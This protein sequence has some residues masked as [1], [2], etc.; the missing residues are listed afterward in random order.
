[1]LFI[2]STG[3]A[4]GEI[5]PRYRDAGFFGINAE[6]P[7]V[8]VFHGDFAL[9]GGDSWTDYSI[10]A[11]VSIYETS[12]AGAH[13]G[14]IVRSDDAGESFYYFGIYPNDNKWRHYSSGD[15]QPV[16][17]SYSLELA[18]QSYDLKITAIQGSLYL[19]INGVEVGSINDVSRLSGGAGL[20]MEYADASF[21]NVRINGIPQDPAEW[22]MGHEVVWSGSPDGNL[23][24]NVL[25]DP[26][27][28]AS[29]D[30]SPELDTRF[31]MVAEMGARHVRFHLSWAEIQPQG[32][33]QPY[34]WRYADALAIAAS[35]YGLEIVPVVIYAPRWAV[36]PE[37]RASKYYY[38]YPP[39][40]AYGSLDTG[41][42][43]EFVAA[44]AGRYMKDGDLAAAMNWNTPDNYAGQA[45]YF[46]IGPEYNLGTLYE[47][48]N[49]VWGPVG[50]GW[51]GSLPQF[52]DLLMAGRDAVKSRCHLCQVLNG[53]AA[54]DSI[55][56]YYIGDDPDRYDGYVPY[57]DSSRIF[58]P[59]GTP[60]WR[61][62]VWQGVNDLYNE[63]ERR[64]PPDNVP[65]RYFDILNIHTFMWK[66][67]TAEMPAT[68]DRYVNCSFYANDCREQWYEKRL[69]EVIRVM[70]NHND[71]R[72]I[73][74]TETGFASARPPNDTLGF[75][76]YLS[77]IGQAQAL[78]TAYAVSARYP[79]VKKVFWWQ[80]YDSSYTGYL[81]LINQ[82]LSGKL[83][84]SRFGWMTGKPFTLR[85]SD[86]FT[87]YDDMHADNW[88]LMSNPA[89]SSG[90]AWFE[91]SIAGKAMKLPA[92]SG[93]NPGQIPP[94]KTV[95]VRYKGL[96]GGPVNAGY[97]ATSQ[98]LTSQRT[99]W[100]G[101][102]LEEVTG[103]AVRQSDH[104]YWAWYDQLSSGYK[105]WVLVSNPGNVPAFYQVKIAGAVKAKGRVNPGRTIPHQFAGIMG[106][107]VEVLSCADDFTGPGGGCLNPA[108]VTASQRVLM[109]ED[110][111]FN[112]MPGIPA[113]GL[114]SS[115][116]W[117]WYD[118]KSPGS[119]NWVLIANPP[120]AADPI[121]Y[122][123][124]VAGKAL[125][126]G[127]PVAPGTSA[128]PAF[129]G[130]MGGPVEVRTYSDPALT[131]PAASI[132]SQRVL[133]GK[134]FEEVPGYRSE[135]LSSS[136]HWTWYDMK[137]PGSRNWVL[138]ANPPEA[139]DPIY[140]EI[141]VAGKALAAGGP[142]APGTSATPAFPGVMG[143][144]VEVRTYSDPALTVPAASIASQRVLWGGYIHELA[145]TRLD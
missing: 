36:T 134:S 74:L 53:G 10:E 45:R 76:G 62:T 141:K 119:R 40:D 104:F 126:A 127:G 109:S 21:T 132:A 31:R 97:S 118:M 61:Q 56:N 44:A 79:Q 90:D 59:D 43:S 99:L 135:L 46:E 32:P 19:F 73:W 17:G 41:R 27:L 140:Y 81:G 37:F 48:R 66:G 64:P 71:S 25:L 82:D 8:D 80:A 55:T 143:G 113:A 100:A 84:Y 83:S 35:R 68:V 2:F 103:S 29:P 133:W 91:L 57:L 6:R 20:H 117:T 47:W 101:S 138:I 106:G 22:R 51:L 111:D 12:A 38:A 122:E 69:E 15:W 16:E 18:P 123:I 39:V 1:M 125:A 11:T 92:I 116:H 14:L 110:T 114:S 137:S 49:G 142:V 131:V 120:E 60:A 112:E 75:L 54:D 128:T 105:N 67:Y 24:G 78:E 107:P 93:F 129:P 85:G 5:A 52:V 95:H 87:W 77:E 33:D 50:A 26:V 102:S 72:D 30:L 9:T 65:A 88:V 86:Y 7:H 139:A 136:Y 98:A 115:Y 96:M 34:A 70:E 4:L 58:N 144:P 23:R 89:S 3:S 42:F 94:G 124:K 121:Y 130:V 108:L 28:L 145:G 13:A 63:I